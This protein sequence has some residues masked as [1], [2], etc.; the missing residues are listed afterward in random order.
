MALLRQLLSTALNQVSDALPNSS[1]S[2]AGGA[3]H[4]CELSVGDE[5]LQ[6]NGMTVSR[7]TQV[8]I[9]IL[10]RLGIRFSG[11][12]NRAYGGSSQNWP[13]SASGPKNQSALA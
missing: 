1:N 7:L 3:A 12:N 4:M 6:M 11:A 10:T 5:V 13:A 8:F 2:I 9:R